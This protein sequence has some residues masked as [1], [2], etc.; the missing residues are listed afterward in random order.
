V[1]WVIDPKPGFYRHKQT[2][3]KR[4]I[5]DGR[6]NPHCSTSRLLSISS[7]VLN[8]RSV[9]QQ[10]FWADYVGGRDFGLLPLSAFFRVVRQHP[11][12]AIRELGELQVK[13]LVAE[14]ELG[15]L[16]DDPDFNLAKP[17]DE[18]WFL[19]Q[20]IDAPRFAFASGWP[21]TRISIDCIAGH[22]LLSSGC[23]ESAAKREWHCTEWGCQAFQLNLW[24]LKNDRNVL[25]HVQ[26]IG[27]FVLEY[28]GV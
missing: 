26:C 18:W 7:V 3:P 23:R 21:G 19:R 24:I 13:N 11:T 12:T 22:P 10:G 2:E 14:E 17:G 9:E 15:E 20:L 1:D 5:R 25:F 27:Q 6:L 4:T 16:E 28:W 8:P